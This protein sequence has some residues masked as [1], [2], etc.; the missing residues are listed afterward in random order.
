MEIFDSLQLQLDD[1]N[2]NIKTNLKEIQD[3]YIK[4]RV[5]EE[6]SD[7]RIDEELE[8]EMEKRLEKLNISEE[9]EEG[10]QEIK[11]DNKIILDLFGESEDELEDVDVIERLNNI[12]EENERFVI[13]DMTNANDL[14]M[15]EMKKD[16]IMT[17]IKNVKDEKKFENMELDYINKI[18]ADREK[19]PNMDEKIDEKIVS[20]SFDEKLEKVK[21]E[22]ERTDKRAKKMAKCSEDKEINPKT[23]KCVKKCKPGQTR[24]K[25][26]FRCKKVK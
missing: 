21:K 25:D 1:I 19:Y 24:D 4:D 14:I 23:G 6:E 16:E 15:K 18:N 5:I 7:E 17:K 26:T 12:L 9:Q 8:E 2:F 3:K 11:T 20:E 22:I 10:E 13:D